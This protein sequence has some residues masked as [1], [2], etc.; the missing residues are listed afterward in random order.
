M[1]VNRHPNSTALGTTPH[2]RNG[3]FTYSVIAKL[4]GIT[5]GAAEMR[6]R[7][8]DLR[9]AMPYDSLAGA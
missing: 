7:S 1:N 2:L 3:G 4:M 5:T 8:A 6:C 9:S